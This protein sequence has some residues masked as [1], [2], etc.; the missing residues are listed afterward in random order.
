MTGNGKNGLLAVAIIEAIAWA[1][2]SSQRDT[3]QL[4]SLIFQGSDSIGVAVLDA[5]RAQT[6]AAPTLT[7][8]CPE[9]SQSPFRFYCGLMHSPEADFRSLAGCEIGLARLPRR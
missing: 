3:K 7:S 5:R 9:E 2:H 1:I 6:A 4:L 8:L